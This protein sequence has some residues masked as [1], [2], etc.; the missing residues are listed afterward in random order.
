VRQHQPQVG[1]VPLR[2]LTRPNRALAGMP[3]IRWSVNERVRARPVPL[4]VFGDE[5]E[6]HNLH[7]EQT[8]D[9]PRKSRFDFGNP[10]PDLNEALVET[11]PD[12]Y[13]DSPA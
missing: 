2:D 10:L 7:A 9:L 11:A 6:D 5:R 12:A 8:N 3:G 4:Q 13:R 1:L